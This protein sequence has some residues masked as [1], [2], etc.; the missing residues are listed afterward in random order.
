MLIENNV[1]S[2][3]N[4][5][6]SRYSQQINFERLFETE[7]IFVGTGASSFMIEWFAKI[8]IKNFCLIDNAKV[9]RKNLPVQNFIASDIGK[10][11]VDA[12]AER[13]KQSA[14]ESNNSL[15]PTIEVRTFAIDFLQ[16]DNLEI[17]RPDLIHP[18]ILIM[19]TDYH[20][21]QA[22]GARLSIMYG[23]PT[24]WAGIYKN[25]MAGEIIFYQKNQSLPCYRCITK[26][27]YE[28]F[29]NKSQSNK[30][31]QNNIIGRGVSSGLPMAATQLDSMLSHLIIGC[32]HQQEKYN[33]HGQL[34]NRLL[35]EKRNLIQTQFSPD[36]LLNG[37]DIFSDIYGENTVTFNTLFQSVLVQVDCEDCG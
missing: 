7:L 35:K 22:K 19:T 2:E 17:L 33:Q 1:L 26:K 14:F 24:F 31:Q 36:Y 16:L 23:I 5:V 25:S 30:N 10:N 9:E 34:Y 29:V 21:V 12:L 8:G 15:L 13:I 11:K 4:N 6:Y 3:L 18:K 28:N 27:R 37:N 20:P 32:I